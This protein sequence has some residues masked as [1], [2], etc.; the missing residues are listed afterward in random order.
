[1]SVDVTAGARVDLEVVAPARVT[2]GGSSALVVGPPGAPAPP[3]SRQ[4]EAVLDLLHYGTPAPLGFDPSTRSA[5]APD[6]WT[7]ARGCGGR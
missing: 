5:A 4:P 2:I 3:A 7:G 6:S 1:M